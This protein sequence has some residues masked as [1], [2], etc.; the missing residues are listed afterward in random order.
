MK[1]D[2]KKSEVREIDYQNYLASSSD[3]EG[4]EDYPFLDAPLPPP[5]AKGARAAAEHAGL[6]GVDGA[7]S[8]EEEE[9]EGRSLTF[10]PT[11][12][13]AT[14]EAS[15]SVWQRA[16]RE[17]REKRKARRKAKEAEEASEEGSEEA[18][19]EGSEEGSEE[20]EGGYEGAGEEDDQMDAELRD[21]PFFAD[22]MDEDD[23]QRGALGGKGSA[24]RAQGAATAPKKGKKGKKGETK[25]A[26]S[27]EEAAEEAKRA[28]E[29]ELLVMD[30]E[31]EEARGYDAKKLQL[32]K[33]QLR[34]PKGGSRDTGKGASRRRDKEQAASA[35]H[36]AD[37]FKMDLTDPRFDKMFK[38]QEFGIDPT[39][40]KF[41]R[42]HA[43]EQVLGEMRKRREVGSEPS[44]VRA[45]RGGGGGLTL[46]ASE[47]RQGQVQ[48][49][50]AKA[51][52][53][54]WRGDQEESH[55]D[56]PGDQKSP[57][58]IKSP[59]EMREHLRRGPKVCVERSH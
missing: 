29:L 9:E 12:A 15:Q 19:E 13:R 1:R 11:K 37:G 41:K 50:G 24:A 14:D 32:P 45:T 26:L 20:E 30:E 52:Q 40:P 42:T 55:Q 33:K 21:D 51:E 36:E 39:H 58:E 43:T 25:R 18:S 22:A 53:A 47:R 4:E 23:E 17:I 28:A 5:R 57:A 16:Q 46:Q 38:S 3:G 6:L 56:Q 2:L 54:G 27:A 8:E 49:G 35:E 59:A 44:A 10:V 7:P 34:L 31:K 48:A